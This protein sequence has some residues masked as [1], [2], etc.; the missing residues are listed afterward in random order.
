MILMWLGPLAVMF[1]GLAIFRRAISDLTVPLQKIFLQA[2]VGSV[3]TMLEKTLLMAFCQ[4]SLLQNQWGAWT[5]LSQ[6][7]F[8]SRW[9]ILLL[10]LAASGLWTS[11][12]G[13]LVMFQLNGF[14]VLG[15]AVI[16]YVVF[17]WTGRFADVAKL[18]GGL[19][20]FMVGAEEALRNQSV[21]L[22]WLGD[23]ELRFLL[24]DGRWPAQLLW[25]AVALLVTL[26]VGIEAWSL[27]VSLLLVAA[28]ALS[29]NGAIAFLFG[30]A[31]AWAL[32]QGRKQ[33]SYLLVS[34]GALLVAFFVCGY[35]RDMISWNSDLDLSQM[36][37]RDLQVLM[38]FAVLWGVQTFAWM[39]WGH[40]GHAGVAQKLGISVS[41]RW[42]SRGWISRALQE[43]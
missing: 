22:N 6:K 8:P 2:P 28:G 19:G 12:V 36:G 35:I 5:L 34:F 31:L 24:A 15:L 7:K 3:T 27:F 26:C 20:L 25:I 33:R 17:F 21:L 42:Q 14:Y 43:H 29:L 37:V 10:C 38:F 9:A 30:E 23:Q 16:F 18:F 39:L 41:T 40:F 11:V 32:W 1:F 13:G 4:G